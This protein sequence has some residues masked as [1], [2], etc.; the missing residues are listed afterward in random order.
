MASMQLLHCQAPV[1][2]QDFKFGKGNS[3][4]PKQ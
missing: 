1:L 3:L 2:A 4:W